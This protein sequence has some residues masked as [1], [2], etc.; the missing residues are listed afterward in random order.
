MLVT[1]RKCNQNIVQ[2]ALPLHY[3]FYFLF[4]HSFASAQP[5]QSS[6]HWD[7]RWDNSLL[8]QVEETGQGK[9]FYQPPCWTV[10]NTGMSAWLVR[11]GEVTHCS[12]CRRNLDVQR[13]GLHVS[14]LPVFAQ[15]DK[16]DQREL[17]YLDWKR[18]RIHSCFCASPF[19][20]SI[21]DVNTLCTLGSKPKTMAK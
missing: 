10:H 16:A 6:S 8:L 18:W 5:S 1:S 11:Y 19:A 2:I 20:W 3:P 13:Q 15:K 12:Q 4:L 21:A 9:G 17:V 14:E 7:H